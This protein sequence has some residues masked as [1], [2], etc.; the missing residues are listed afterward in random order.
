[1]SDP[2]EDFDEVTA[3]A[4]RLRAEGKST[5]EIIQTIY[6][7]A[8]P[9]EAYA[10]DRAMVDG[11][12]LPL[13]VTVHPWSLIDDSK[14]DLD[15]EW[16]QQVEDDAFARWPRFLPLMVLMAEDAIHGNHII[17]YDLDELASGKRTIFG[18]DEKHPPEDGPLPSL[19]PSLLAVLREWMAD[20]HRMLDE[21]H[22]SPM[23]RGA[24]SISDHTVEEAA[25]QLRA[26]EALQRAN[27]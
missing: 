19:G 12:R 9:A 21:Q 24:G 22:R 1:M 11:I 18:F 25:A 20:H 14:R 17:G 7:V 3:T 8:L 4:D 6:G 10:L 23:N 5:A 15:E 16:A 26:I 2:R 27:P 13:V